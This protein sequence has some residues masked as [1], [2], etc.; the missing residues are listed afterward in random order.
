MAGRGKGRGKGLSF[1]LETF[2][3]K[4][5]DFIQTRALEPPSLYPPLLF[6]PVALNTTEVDNYLIAVKQELRL[7]FKNSRF[8]LDSRKAKNAVVKYSDKYENIINKS[9]TCETVADLDCRLFPEEI[10]QKKTRIVRKKA[11]SEIDVTK[12]LERLKDDE[13]VEKEKS[14]SGEEEEQNEEVT[15]NVEE[16]IEEETDYA[17]SYFDNGEGYLE[18]SDDYLD[19]GPTY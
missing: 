17:L 18:D 13:E 10:R 2:G 14:E 11:K 15:E 3:L 5:S 4:S 8:Y 16:E 19:E 12:K 6:K 9:A 7:H 1:N